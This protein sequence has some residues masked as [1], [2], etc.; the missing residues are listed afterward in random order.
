MSAPSSGSI[1]I[2]APSSGSIHMSAPSS[3]SIYMYLTKVTD[4]VSIVQ[5]LML[6][7]IYN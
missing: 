2:S 5:V 7:T 6:T 1:H 3:G 4:N